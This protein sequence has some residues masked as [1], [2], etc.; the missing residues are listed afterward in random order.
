MNWVAGAARIST[1]IL[2]FPGIVFAF[3]PV[4]EKQLFSAQ[5]TAKTGQKG[6]FWDFSNFCAW[7]NQNW[8]SMQN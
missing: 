1:P 8:I 3:E 6:M 4:A 2:V 7:K 5:K